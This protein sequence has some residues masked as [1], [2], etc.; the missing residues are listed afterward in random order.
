M[1][2]NQFDLLM[3]L[4]KL[5]NV[6]GLLF[7]LACVACDRRLFRMSEAFFSFFV[8]QNLVFAQPDSKTSASDVHK[9]LRKC[10]LCRP[11]FHWHNFLLGYK[12]GVMLQLSAC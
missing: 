10:L 1:Q 12:N 11:C 6:H 7:L 9:G 3:V 2:L 5:L 8:M 4:I